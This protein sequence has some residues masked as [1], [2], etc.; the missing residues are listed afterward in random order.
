[1]HFQCI[2]TGLQINGVIL[3]HQHA[4]LEMMLTNQICFIVYIVVKHKSLELQYVPNIPTTIVYIAKYVSE[5]DGWFMRG[6]AVLMLGEAGLCVMMAG[7]C[8]VM[9][10]LCMVMAGLCMVMAGLCVVMAGLCVNLEKGCLVL[11]SL[12]L[13]LLT[14]RWHLN[15]VQHKSANAVRKRTCIDSVS[16]DKRGV[17]CVVTVQ[18]TVII[19]VLNKGNIMF[20]FISN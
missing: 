12:C 3:R 1:M 19:D 15:I 18:W 20:S 8:V 14:N 17:R 10:G 7:L 9:A 16:D 13:G 5:G 4:F 11:R 2:L 6:E